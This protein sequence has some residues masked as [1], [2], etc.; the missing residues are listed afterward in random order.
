M[1]PVVKAAVVWFT[2]GLCCCEG[3]SSLVVE[4]WCSCQLGA[5]KKKKHTGKGGW[6]VVDKTAVDV[7]QR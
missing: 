6:G 7:L 5:V 2:K 4:L 1:S 3:A